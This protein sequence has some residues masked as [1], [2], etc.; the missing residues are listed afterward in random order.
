MSYVR[1]E[2]SSLAA[3]KRA[4]QSTVLSSRFSCLSHPECMERSRMLNVEVPATMFVGR[5]GLEKEGYGG[6]GGL[7]QEMSGHVG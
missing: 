3:L 4:C 2:A 7:R 5:E 6:G 1:Q